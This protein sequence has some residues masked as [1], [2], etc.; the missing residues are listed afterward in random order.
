MLPTM[1]ARDDDRRGAA[2]YGRD[3]D[4]ELI[5]A[6]VAAAASSPTPAAGEVPRPQPPIRDASRRRQ[7]VT[8][9]LV[10]AAAVLAVGVAVNV[11]TLGRRA[12]PPFEPRPSV[13]AIADA[14][15]RT[16][17]IPVTIDG[18]PADCRTAIQFTLQDP[19]PR[20]VAQLGRFETFVRHHRWA[21]PPTSSP[22]PA[23]GDPASA[24]KAAGAVPVMDAIGEGVREFESRRGEGPLVDSLLMTANTECG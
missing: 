20:A 19:S 23:H 12:A 7:V 6:L 24:G 22:A 2:V 16:R 18:G 13:T 14:L 8:A 4:P 5:A 15:T 9:I 11:G 1:A 3:P 21:V 17:T 10:A